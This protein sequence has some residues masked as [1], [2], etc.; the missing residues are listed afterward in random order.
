VKFPSS[1]SSGM[2]NLDG[3][4]T[5][6]MTGWIDEKDDHQGYYISSH[7]SS[8]GNLPTI[9]KKMARYHIS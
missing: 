9:K 5:G 6:Q 1:S 2:R 4:M 3:W 8:F 7:E